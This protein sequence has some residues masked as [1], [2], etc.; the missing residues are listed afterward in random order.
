MNEMSE[1]IAF[2]NKVRELCTRYY[3]P[4]KTLSNGEKNPLDYPGMKG[5]VTAAVEC[6]VSVAR[7]FKSLDN[8]SPGYLMP[9]IIDLTFGLNENSF[10]KQHTAILVPVFKSAIHAKITSKLIDLD[11]YKT[12]TKENIKERQAK[13]WYNLFIIAF[14]C[15]YGSAKTIEISSAILQEIESIM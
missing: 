7:V 6:M 9:V 12:P 1:Q 14:D 11:Q 2:S 3:T 5:E 13:Q 4:A 10:W 8:C 15:M